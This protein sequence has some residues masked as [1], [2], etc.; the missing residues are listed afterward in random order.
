MIDG[1]VHI[2]KSE[3]STRYFLL[4]SYIKFSTSLDFNGAVVMPNI[5]NNMKAYD[6][7]KVFLKQIE[8]YRDS[9]K[10]FPFLLIEPKSKLVL[11]QIQ[12]NRKIIYGLKY[13]PSVYRNVISNNILKPFI[14]ISQ[15]L[16]IP[17]LVHCGRNKQ[18]HI[19]HLIKAATN[20]PNINFIAAHLGG[21]ASDLIDEA[22]TL[23]KPLKLKNLYLDTS[24]VKLPWLIER[25]VNEIG[26]DKIIFG[27]DEPYSDLRMSKYCIEL[28]DISNKE[29]IYSD[30]ILKLLKR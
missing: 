4:D 30:N 13:H 6:L 20:N 1:H 17:I 23:L 9:F 18:S 15:E 12:E 3:K 29:N 24:A 10:L 27:S 19:S 11:E 16:N 2:G 26:Y 25:A 5:S 14:N 22:I 21:N 7:N 28:S 8:S